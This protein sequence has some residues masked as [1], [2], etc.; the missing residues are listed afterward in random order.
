MD[1]GEA[2]DDWVRA[3]GDSRDQ[4]P[5]EVEAV[6]LDDQ[7][8]PTADAR[9]MYADCKGNCDCPRCTRKEP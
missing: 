3:L 8:R 6:F 5:A 1:A 2:F 7:G 4:L 9:Q